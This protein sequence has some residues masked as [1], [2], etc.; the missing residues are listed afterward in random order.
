MDLEAMDLDG[1]GE[2]TEEV[3]FAACPPLSVEKRNSASVGWGW[4]G[5]GGDA[6]QAGLRMNSMFDWNCNCS[7]N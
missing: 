7:F 2:R 6:A 4:G 1:R 5:V 3:S